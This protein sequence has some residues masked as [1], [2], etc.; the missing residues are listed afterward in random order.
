MLTAF[1]RLLTVATFVLTLVT[2]VLTEFN[3]L[4]NVKTAPLFGIFVRSEASPIYLPK[5]EPDEIV[6]KNP[7]LVD[8]VAAEILQAVRVPVLSPSVLMLVA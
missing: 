5:I 4:L 1:N 2:F 6:E 8:I 7:K 3:R